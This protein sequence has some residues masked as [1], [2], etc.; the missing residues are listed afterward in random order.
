MLVSETATAVIIILFIPCSLL[1]KH[2]HTKIHI[3]EAGTW[4]HT[5]KYTHNNTKRE[6][7]E[8]KW[9]TL[10]VPQ[11]TMTTSGHYVTN[12]EKWG[13]VRVALSSLWKQQRKTESLCAFSLLVFI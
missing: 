8:L 13:S 6:L 10:D 5:L 7:T 12:R 4:L 11:D 2:I 1:L 3:C 9:M